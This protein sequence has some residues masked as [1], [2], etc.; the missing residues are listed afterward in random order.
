MVK[1]VGRKLVESGRDWYS[2]HCTNFCRTNGLNQHWLRVC[3][4]VDSGWELQ[5]NEGA[6][7][8]PISAAAL[9][10]LYLC[11]NERADQRVRSVG[12]IEWSP[13]SSLGEVLK[14]RGYGQLM[15]K[16]FERFDM[17]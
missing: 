2:A 17:R 16:L 4:D 8:Q 5:I 1:K 15:P 12:D 3:G 10:H 13:V 11:G 14:R 7:T 6:V 9:Y